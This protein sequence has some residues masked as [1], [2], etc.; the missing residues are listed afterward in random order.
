[1]APSPKNAE[2]MEA[3]VSK[4]LQANESRPTN[5]EKREKK[6]EKKVRKKQKQ[7]K[8]QQKKEHKAQQ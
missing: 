3:V 2:E 8:Q 5:G 4:A 7:Q 6:R 1:M